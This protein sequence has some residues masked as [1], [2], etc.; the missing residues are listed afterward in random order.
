[1]QVRDFEQ[2]E[3]DFYWRGV[4]P[5]HQRQTIA[6]A[7]VGTNLLVQ[8]VIVEQLVQLFEHRVDALCHLWHARKHLFGLIA[9][10]KHP[11]FLLGTV[12]AR[13]VLSF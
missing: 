3:E 4:S 13:F 11:S 2:T 8:R 10:N 5:M 9:V 6:L 12:L 7:K 1:M